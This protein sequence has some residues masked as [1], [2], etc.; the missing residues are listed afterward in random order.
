MMR[1]MRPDL[2]FDV[3]WEESDTGWTGDPKGLTVDTV[4][5]RRPERSVAEGV[6]EALEGLGWSK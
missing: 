2:P 6:R 3:T 1:A 4:H 5:P